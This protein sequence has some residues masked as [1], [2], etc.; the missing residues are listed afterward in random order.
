MNR[1]RLFC[2]R[3]KDAQL[4]AQGEDLELE[5]GTGP[6]PVSYDH[7]QKSYGIAHAPTLPRFGQT[8]EFLRRMGFSEGTA[9]MVVFMN[10]G[11]IGAAL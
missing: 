2:C 6:K 11:E 7:G 3:L 5:L 1:G 10:H 8:R 4:V 9:K